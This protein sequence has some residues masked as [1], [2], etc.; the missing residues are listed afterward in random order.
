MNEQMLTPIQN[1]H[2]NP[3][4]EFRDGQAVFRMVSEAGT[5]IEKL[6]SFEA[7]REAATNIA[8]DSGWLGP[9]VV[10][11]GNGRLGEWVIAFI[12]PGRHTLELTVGTPGESEQVVKV[13]APLPGIVMFGAA[14]KYWV[15]AQKGERCDPQ[16]ELYRC[17]LPNVM[18]DGLICWGPFKPP[19]ASPRSIMRAWEIFAGSTFTNHAANG[20]SKSH[21]EDVRVLLREL[22]GGCG[23]YCAEDVGHVD[24][25]EPADRYPVEDLVRQLDHTGVTLDKAIREFWKAGSMPE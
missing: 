14:V 17:P 19:Q 25:R 3:A 9:E 5:V 15:W 7:I 18:Q 23:Y 22:A 10:R 16:G 21:H 13:M 12:P 20:K 4:L 6:V 24:H 11:W 1:A 8:V 2:T